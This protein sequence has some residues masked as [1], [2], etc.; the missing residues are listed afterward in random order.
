MILIGSKAAAI[1]QH[2]PQIADFMVNI[3]H[4]TKLASVGDAAGSAASASHDP[5]VIAAADNSE[6]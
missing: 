3:A 1:S 5:R 2:A 6:P 4:S